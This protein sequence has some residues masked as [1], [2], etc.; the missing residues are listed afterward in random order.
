M[1]NVDFFRDEV[2]CGFYIPTAIKQA[3]AGSLQVLYEVDRICQKYDIMYFAEWGS[4]LG[5][6]RHGGFVPWD[7]D[8]DIGMKRADYIR[9]RRVA[10][11]EFGEGFALQ[12]FRNTEDH[13]QFITR[14]VNKNHICFEEEHL[15][16]YHNFPYIASIDIFLLDYVY[17]DEEKET[18]R[19]E[20]VKRILAVADGILDESLRSET[21]QRELEGFE[22]T[23]H[24]RFE[25]NAGKIELGR[26][27]YDLAEKQ[28]A[29]TR[30]DQADRIS[31]MFPWGLKGVRRLPKEYYEKTVR[32][33]FENT[34]I[35]VPAK[36][37]QILTNRYGDYLKI[38]K[39]WGGHGYPFFEG[40]KKNLE[41]TLGGK[42]HEFEFE[43]I[44]GDF[45]SNVL[46][47]EN[48]MEG[49][50][51]ILF[52]SSGAKE[53]KSL[54]RWYEI[55]KRDGSYD[56]TVI[57]L[58]V[59]FKNALGQIVGSSEE[60]DRAAHMNDYPDDVE[61]TEWWDYEIRK[62]KPE[63]VLLQSPYDGSNPCL[64]VPEEYDIT[65]IRRYVSRIVYIPAFEAEDFDREAI[66]DIYNLKHYLLTPTVVCS[67]LMLTKSRVLRDRYI[68]KLT[69][70]AGES[71]KTYWEKKIQVRSDMF[72]LHEKTQ[73]L[74]DDGTDETAKKGEKV[75]L[76][77][78]GLNET[79]ENP[80]NFEA[81][82]RDRLLTMELAG[83]RIWVVAS[84]YPREKETWEKAAKGM[85]QKLTGLLEGKV[86]LVDY[87]AVAGGIQGF[88]AYYGSVSPA[89]VAFLQQ[90]KPAMIADYSTGF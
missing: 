29:R 4:L 61:L 41:E 25:K 10:E 33:P 36:Y 8:L 50:K 63:L 59:V 34:T 30:P 77:L 43:D 14:V 1:L 17:E 46:I 68:E 78:L 12:D 32:L 80:K 54:K 11:Q 73:T 26:D 15:N 65:S 28:M 72:F 56:I 69:D 48:M 57:A 40:Q 90:G 85:R 24:V 76:Y 84:F 51:K 42:L 13:W 35:P 19:C 31:Q 53:W 52:L 39:V 86:E 47:P 74:D 87:A 20:E 58:P 60:I 82:V 88:D 18:A 3:W 66:N 7:D 21:I 6:V 83:D 16:R 70:W 55:L 23:Y 38:H 5:A 44:F 81:G 79:A 27:L 45:S 62:E 75:L 71:T 67:D 37:H 49:V 89:V 2:R 64:C 22:K 9:F